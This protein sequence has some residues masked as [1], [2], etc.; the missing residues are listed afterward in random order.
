MC[1]LRL[2]WVVNANPHSLHLNGLGCLQ[3]PSALERIPSVTRKCKFD[4]EEAHPGI[5][6]NTSKVAVKKGFS[7]QWIVL[8]WH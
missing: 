4:R 7:A 8:R 6:G 5:S 2:Y 3:C 1:T